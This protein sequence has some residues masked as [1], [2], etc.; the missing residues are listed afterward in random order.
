MRS[1][2]LGAHEKVC[3]SRPRDLEIEESKDL[4]SAFADKV[5]EEKEVVDPEIQM[6]RGHQERLA[7]I[8]KEKEKHVETLEREE[9]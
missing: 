5:E 3:E 7:L 9:K 8:L 1:N 6:I 2:K 4:A